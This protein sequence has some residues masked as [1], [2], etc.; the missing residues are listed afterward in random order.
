MIFLDPGNLSIVRE[1]VKAKGDYFAALKAVRT[2]RVY[3]MPSFNQYSTNIAYSLANAY[4]AGTVLY[5][6]AFGDVDF[7]KRFDEIVSFFNGRGWYDQMG[8]LG[9]PY[10]KNAFPG[11]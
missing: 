2:D 5:P 6:E 7:P 4:Y 10:G 3:A 11:L 9:Q 1:E 8:P